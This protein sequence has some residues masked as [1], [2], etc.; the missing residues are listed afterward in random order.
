MARNTHGRRAQGRLRFDQPSRAGSS[1]ARA[2]A[3]GRLRS[4]DG[5]R[6]NRAG[7]AVSGRRS[8]AAV[9]V[10]GRTAQGRLH[11]W[12][13][14]RAAVRAGAAG[15]RRSGRRVV[16]KCR[17]GSASGRAQ[18][19]WDWDSGSQEGETAAG[20]GETETDSRF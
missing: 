17:G 11:G 7:T 20:H 19:A 10:Q 14:S 5:G 2:T 3:Q 16:C 13:P 18:A 9:Q 4:S 1:R 8:C 12:A 15:L 6:A